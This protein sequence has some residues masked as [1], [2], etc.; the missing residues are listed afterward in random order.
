MP[1]FVTAQCPHCGEKNTY[2]LTDLTVTQ[3]GARVF[4]SVS[5]PPQ[6][7]R[8]EY[9]ITCNHCHRPFKVAVPERGGPR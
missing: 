1:P 6:E 9:V 4:R 3:P 8:R 7:G 2:D 5:L